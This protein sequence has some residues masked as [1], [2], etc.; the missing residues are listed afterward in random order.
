MRKIANTLFVAFLFAL[1]LGGLIKTILLPKDINEL[2][3]RYAN[4]LPKPSASEYLSGKM[5]DDMEAAFSDQFPLSDRLIS[6]SN[7]M[8]SRASLAL[9]FRIMETDPDHYYVYDTEKFFHGRLCYAPKELSAVSDVLSA[10][11]QNLNTLFHEQED[12]DFYAYF[13]ENDANINFETGENCGIRDAM[14][15]ALDLPENQKGTF[16]LTGFDDFSRDF[17]ETDHHWNDRGVRRAYKDL[18]AMLGFDPLS[19]AKTVTLE[20]RLSGSKAKSIGAQDILTEEVTVSVYDLPEM[21]V[22]VNGKPGTYGNEAA[23]LSGRQDAVL[24]YGAYFGGD[25]GEVILNTHRPELKNLL[26]IGESYDNALLKL[27]ASH[28]NCTYS[29]DLRYYTP[30]T[31]ETFRLFSYLEA[32]EIDQVLFIGSTAFWTLPEFTVEG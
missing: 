5:Q 19:P 29:V 12:V 22:F 17:Y 21:E 30:H 18:S 26:I 1:L 4:K 10:R 25:E 6:G 7:R 32:H 13:V 3:N 27:L 14:L 20:N 11:A 8:K 24:T 9:L 28:Y 23:F 2:E 15:C 16:C 31:G